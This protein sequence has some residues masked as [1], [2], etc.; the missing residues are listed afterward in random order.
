METIGEK[1][2]KLRKSKRITQEELGFQLNVS[3]QTIHNWEADVMQPNVENIKSI[4]KYFG[5]N[6]DYFFVENTKEYMVSEVA[7]TSDIV[8]RKN[9]KRIVFIVISV[10]LALALVVA[11]IITTTFGCAFF[12]DN[13]GQLGHSTL[14]IDISA[15]IISLVFSAILLCAFIGSII[16]AIKCKD[17]LT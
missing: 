13:K 1:I 6:S 2:S 14:D 5:V 8:R 12:T 3:R 17:T 9:T 4:C 16:L 15:F 7:A 11:L 10:V